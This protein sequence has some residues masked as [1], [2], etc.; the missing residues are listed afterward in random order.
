MRKLHR[1]RNAF[2]W[3]CKVAFVVLTLSSAGLASTVTYDLRNDW[4]T[5]NPNGPWTFLQ[6]TTLLPYQSACDAYVYNCPNTDPYLPLWARI[7]ASAASNEPYYEP[8]DIFTHSVDSYNGIP[9]LGESTLQW[10]A[11]AAGTIDISG[12]LW[13]AHGTCCL[14]RSN[15]FFLS[16]N[17]TLLTSG[18]I[19]GSG[20]Y[21]R[22]DPLSFSFTGD[23]VNAGDTLTLVFRRSANEDLNAGSEDGVNLTVTETT[24]ASQVPEPSSLVLLG[25]GLITTFG[26]LRRKLLL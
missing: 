3:F 13:F 23:H 11:P 5:T 16:L 17:G 7:P 24:A 26:L 9:S 25:T 10:T 8:G 21:F 4:G 22:P 14:D 20:P 12:D 2:G 19:A 1:S 15:D 18:T 6:G